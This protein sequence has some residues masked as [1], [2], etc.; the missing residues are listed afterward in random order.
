MIAIVAQEIGR[1]QMSRRTPVFSWGNKT[2]VG[3]KCGEAS[4]RTFPETKTDMAVCPKIF[5]RA[6]DRPQS[7]PAAQDKSEETNINTTFELMS[8]QFL[9]ISQVAVD[10]QHTYPRVSDVWRPKLPGTRHSSC[11][12]WNQAGASPKL[13][14]L[15]CL[16]VSPTTHTMKHHACN[17][18]WL[19]GIRPS[20]TFTVRVIFNPLVFHTKVQFNHE[21]P[22]KQHLSTHD[23]VSFKT[24]KNGT[25]FNIRSK[26]HIA[27]WPSSPPNFVLNLCNPFFRLGVWFNSNPNPHALA[28]KVGKIK[29]DSKGPEDLAWN[30][31]AS[32]GI[33]KPHGPPRETLHGWKSKK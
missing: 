19:T 2:N 16:T 9:R 8:T 32:R 23:M 29:G 3:S 13:S 31:L 7:I 20:K 26:C 24:K 25:K 12:S 21:Q 10:L 15:W 28:S 18:M 30:E 11:R 4:K 17:V 14:Y 5:T 22:T 27:I 6:E 1:K 33:P